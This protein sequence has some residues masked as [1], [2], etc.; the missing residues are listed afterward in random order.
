M[1]SQLDSKMLYFPLIQLAFFKIW[2]SVIGLCALPIGAYVISALSQSHM[3]SDVDISLMQ[4]DI[5]RSSSICFLSLTVVK[6]LCWT[7]WNLAPILL[8]TRPWART[9]SW[10]WYV[11]S[12]GSHCLWLENRA[13]PNLWLR[14]SSL[15]TCKAMLQ[16]QNSSKP[17]SRWR[18]FFRYTVLP[19]LLPLR[20]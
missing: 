18:G 20:K 14:Q 12:S 9:C 3:I 6:K 7:S 1:V 15:I 19:F 8:A 10:W 17:L 2:L 13:A 4:Q 16:N 11:L 5:Q